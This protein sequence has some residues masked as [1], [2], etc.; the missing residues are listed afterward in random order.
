[1]YRYQLIIEYDGN[2]YIGWQ[3]QKKGKSIQGTLEKILSKILK[4]KITIYGSGRTD[5]GVHAYEQSSH[6]DIKK[7]IFNS[8]KLIKSLNYFLQKKN[9]N[10]L[11]I[12][13]KSLD[14]HAR[15]SATKREY[16]YKILNRLSPSSL[17]KN[18]VWHVIKSLNISEMKRGCDYL[19]GKHDFSSFQSS[20]CGAKNPIRSLNKANVTKKGDQVIFVFESKSFLQQQVRSMV[21]CLKY[22]GE[23]KWDLKKFVK[24]LNSKNRKLCA[25]PAPPCGLFL[26]KISY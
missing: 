17:N 3:K 6:F 1:M 5:A 13:K 23:G 16:T 11:K 19:K 14:F 2:S 9:I 18:K 8:E 10:V 15:F 26:K 12:R 7:K 20:N 24:V 22:L 4:E 21:G 25:P